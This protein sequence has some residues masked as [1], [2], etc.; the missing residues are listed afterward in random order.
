M[1]LT[2]VIHP[3]GQGGFYTETF[4]DENNHELFNMVYDCGS[5]TDKSRHILS[6]LKKYI[7]GSNK[8]IDAV[9]ISH[10][11]ND[12]ING[13]DYLLRTSTVRN[14]FLPQLTSDMIIEAYLYNYIKTGV[15]NNPSN[16]CIANLLRGTYNNTR[17][18]E[19]IESNGDEGFDRGE[20]IAIGDNLK[21]SYPSGTVFTV[22]S[23]VVCPDGRYIKWLYIPFNSP[24][25]TKNGKPISQDQLFSSVIDSNGNIE[26][27]RLSYLMKSKSIDEC[28]GIYSEYFGKD[29]NAYS[30]TL[31]SGLEHPRFISRYKGGRCHRCWNMPHHYYSPNFI[32]TGDFKPNLKLGSSSYVEMM[33]RRLENMKLWDSI[34]GIQVPHHGSRY[35]FNI[36]LYHFPCVGYVSVGS[37]NAH[38]HPHVDTIINIQKAGCAPVVVSEDL[39]SMQ[40]EVYEILCRRIN[41]NV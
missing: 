22:N 29:H 34:S 16:D 6:Y 26:P 31:F 33:K 36:E 32:Y 37:T 14:L 18:V 7:S 28:K 23:R 20:S 2:R 9:F 24:Y 13:L 8:N 17:I 35:N 12:H 1:E 39:N 27:N 30:M 11:H 10:L 40:I 21:P 5:E 19:I 41:N 4:T 3:I 38:H 15:V 25:P